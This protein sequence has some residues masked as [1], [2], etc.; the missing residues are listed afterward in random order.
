M[1]SKSFNEQKS[2]QKHVRVYL[3]DSMLEVYKRKLWY[4][5]LDEFAQYSFSLEA[6]FEIGRT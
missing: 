5:L 6:K 4:G 2:V 1:I 3:V